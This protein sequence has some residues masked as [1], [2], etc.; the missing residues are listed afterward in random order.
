M[1]VGRESYW[2]LMTYI[3]MNRI[4]GYIFL[5]LLLIG[6]FLLVFGNIGMIQLL[7]KRPA[8][9]FF[10]GIFTMLVS[11]AGYLTVGF[12][13]LVIWFASADFLRAVVE[14]AENTRRIK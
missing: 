5:A 14:I 3:R 11:F 8:S 7:F 12:V 2:W 6:A 10:L 4:L 9:E 13:Y 1:Q